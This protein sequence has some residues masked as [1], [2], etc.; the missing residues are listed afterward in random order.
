[1]E[2]GIMPSRPEFLTRNFAIRR[3]A[4]ASCLPQ[5]V[6]D[7]CRAGVHPIY[8]S[9]LLSVAQEQGSSL[10]S[11]HQEDNAG[12]LGDKAL[13][14]SLNALQSLSSP[15]HGHSIGDAVDVVRAALDVVL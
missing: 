7:D 6:E 13:Y 1:M 15:V 12:S 2:S 10:P 3:L 4:F 11:L 9:K 8:T 5:L 14:K